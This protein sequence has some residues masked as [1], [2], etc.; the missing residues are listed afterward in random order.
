MKFDPSDL[1]DSRIV[2][3]TKN[4]QYINNYALES[5]RVHLR[6]RCYGREVCRLGRGR[7]HVGRGR[8]RHPARQRLGRDH[9]IGPLHEL[10]GQRPCPGEQSHRQV[11]PAQQRAGKGGL[12]AARLCRRLLERAEPLMPAGWPLC[13][14]FLGTT[15]RAWCRYST[16]YNNSL[17]S[18]RRGRHDPSHDRQTPQIAP[19][20]TSPFAGGTG[21]PARGLV[22]VH[23][24]VGVGARS[25]RS[26][27]HRAP[28]TL[29]LGAGRGGRAEFGREDRGVVAARAIVPAAPSAVP[30]PRGPGKNQRDKEV[31]SS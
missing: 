15:A 26:A 9:R 18:G 31:G 3:Y 22:R 21:P 25:I 5:R 1:N 4:W 24:P 28:R 23:Q 8:G 2:D 12:P 30:G 6:R 11:L 19:S 16:C 29:R 20:P 14:R 27:R 13:S 17:D 10:H 7:S